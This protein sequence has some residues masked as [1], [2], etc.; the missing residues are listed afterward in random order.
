MPVTW[1]DDLATGIER[2]DAQHR[3]L[4]R[5]VAS[6]KETMRRGA[7]QEAAAT[8]E[9]L[10]VYVTDHFDEEERAMQAAQYPGLRE[11][12]A[13]HAALV[14]EF[15]SY[16]ARFLTEGATPSLTVD[17]SSWLVGW[18]G[19]HIRK[20]DAEMARFLRSGPAAR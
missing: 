11:H 13:L 19:N 8:V 17:L 7:T 10:G 6:L 2:I 1:T 20:A 9:F 3:A 18:L 15:L 4:Y 14:Q 12:A 16:R 5:T